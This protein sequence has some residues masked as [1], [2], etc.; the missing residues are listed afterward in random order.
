MTK[1]GKPGSDELSEDEDVGVAQ[2]RSSL[3]FDT[4]RT[5]FLMHLCFGVTPLFPQNVVDAMTDDAEGGIYS[6]DAANLSWPNGAVK[7]VQLYA[8][9]SIGLSQEEFVSHVANVAKEESGRGLQRN[10]NRTP[11]ESHDARNAST[12]DLSHTSEGT[13]DGVQDTISE[14]S[15]SSF[16]LACASSISLAHSKSESSLPSR[17]S[18]LKGSAGISALSTKRR[19]D[20]GLS[21]L[22]KI[23]GR[24]TLF[25]SAVGNDFTQSMLNMPLELLD[26]S[27]ERGIHALPRLLV[28]VSGDCAIMMNPSASKVSSL[29]SAQA[30]ETGRRRSDLVRLPLSSA[31]AGYADASEVRQLLYLPT[32]QEKQYD[33]DPPSSFRSCLNLLYVYPR[34]LCVAQDVDIKEPGYLQLQGKQAKNEFISY[35]VRIQLVKSSLT[36]NKATGQMESSQVTLESFHNPAPWAGPQMLQAIYTKT[37]D[38]SKAKHVEHDLYNGGI[39][40]R[41]EIKMRLPMVLDG[42]YFLH[43]TLFSVKFNDD[44]GGGGVAR[45]SGVSIDAL[46]ETTVPLSSSS[47][48]EPASGARVTTVI[49]N[50]C[51]RVRLGDYQLNIETRLVSSIHVCD[52]TLAT[53]L[54]DFPY[55]KDRS[56]A[57]IGDKF[58][59]FALVPS[60]SVLE[61][62]LGAEP[63]VDAGV[64]FRQLFAKSSENTILGY[65]PVLVYMHLCNLVNAS[66]S[67]L[68][69]S[70]LMTEEI[71]SE[72]FTGSE[73]SAKFAMENMN[74]LLEVLRKVKIKLGAKSTS[75]RSHKRADLFVKN[76]VDNFD[77]TSLSRQKGRSN[78]SDELFDGTLTEKS[79]SS[80]S[81]ATPQKN[82]APQHDAGDYSDDS[83]DEDNV[84]LVAV[85]RRNDGLL[86]SS[87]AFNASA[88]P[89]SRVAFGASKTD[90]MR[91]EAELFHQSNQ[92]THLFDDDETVVTNLYSLATPREEQYGETRQREVDLLW[93]YIFPDESED[94]IISHRPSNQVTDDQPGMET[95]GGLGLNESA[96]AKRVRTA[97][98]VMIA[99]CMAPSLSAVLT[100][101]GNSPQG[102]E[103]DKE[104]RKARMTAALKSRVDPS[105]AD[106][107]KSI[108]ERQ[109]VRRLL[110]YFN[111]FTSAHHLIKD[112]PRSCASRIGC[113][114]RNRFL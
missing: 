40:F 80:S 43:F 69:L 27:S 89:F 84:S 74:S 67:P 28:D 18:F 72:Q 5:Q 48:R 73:L 55:A 25:T 94:S 71:S 86:R 41:D 60:R 50:G 38:A 57:S 59:E 13:S 64:S 61:K 16:P 62:S 30:F 53:V 29:P 112:E 66:T 46:A 49:P 32:R 58:S 24:A 56:D 45:G 68:N 70:T 4:F 31:P 107:M 93:D 111:T 36:L 52:P 114:R 83:D 75:F 102:V 17:K 90:R 105:I 109:E 98:Q 106:K 21:Q 9:P 47:N 23:A 7:E 91:V 108:G 92:F 101:A 39:A 51:H 19:A 34:L 10:R 97:A 87:S 104:T 78:G 103:H 8:L 110:L 1:R 63:A 85:R 99:P 44:F 33:V 88:A 54:R 26:S 96:F 3:T 77:E 81:L 82:R 35:S 76:F 11:N 14:D 2:A 113:R 42:S 65:F 6:L 22:E 37:N 100:G 15:S 12:G 79:R 95:A 20:S